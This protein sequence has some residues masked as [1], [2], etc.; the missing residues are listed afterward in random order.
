MPSKTEPTDN[1]EEMR[2]KVADAFNAVTYDVRTNVV[3][4]GHE[5]YKAGLETADIAFTA[6]AEKIYDK[7]RIFDYNLKM[8]NVRR[9]TNSYE[10]AQGKNR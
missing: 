4:T 7:D 8:T 5:L 6:I 3:L 1:Q 2:R 9:F 10:R